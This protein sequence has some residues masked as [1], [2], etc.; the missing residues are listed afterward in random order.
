R[1][2]NDE[3]KKAK[4]NPIETE[5]ILNGMSAILT[6]FN[7]GG[8]LMSD[9]WEGIMS[10]M[11]ESFDLFAGLVTKGFFDIVRDSIFTVEKNVDGSVK[12]ISGALSK[13]FKLDPKTG[14]FFQNIEN[15]K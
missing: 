9:T 3:L 11:G 1:Q 5:A 12:Y 15:I 6:A 4:D 2:F 14:T 10:N 7:V 13:I 8:R